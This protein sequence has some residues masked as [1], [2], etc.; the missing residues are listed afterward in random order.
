ELASGMHQLAWLASS[1]PMSLNRLAQKWLNFIQFSGVRRFLIATSALTAHEELVP[2]VRTV[3]LDPGRMPEL[4]GYLKRIG[5][6]RRPTLEDAAKVAEDLVAQ[7]KAG[8]I[9]EEARAIVNL[10]QQAGPELLR[11]D[12]YL[13]VL[14]AAVDAS[15]FNFRPWDF[16]AYWHTPLGRMTVLFRR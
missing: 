15:A 10:R 2:M 7:M 13:R 9:P 6:G 12:P 1:E 14:A 8:Q 3:L 4:A 11:K 5:F 16:P